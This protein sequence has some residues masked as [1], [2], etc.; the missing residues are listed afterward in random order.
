VFDVSG[1]YRTEYAHYRSPGYSGP[2]SANHAEVQ[3]ALRSRTAP[4]SVPVVSADGRFEGFSAGDGQNHARRPEGSF[5]HR[6]IEDVL[7]G[8]GFRDNEVAL[9]Y[10]G[11]WLRDY[12][13]LL[14]PKVV[15]PAGAAKDLGRFLSRPALTAIVDILATAEFAEQRS[16][17]PADYRVTPERLGVYRPSEHIDNPRN[18]TPLPPDPRSIDADFEPWVL[19]GDPLLSI[20]PDLSMKRYILRSKDYMIAQIR[21]AQAQGRNVDGFRTFG[22]ALHVLEDYFAHS[23]FCELSLRKLGYTTVLPWTSAAP[24]RHRYPVVTGMFGPTDVIASMAEPIAHALFN[25]ESWSFEARNAGDRSDGEKIMLVLLSEHSDPRYL[26][27]F[28]DFLKARDALLRLPGRPLLS[29][30]GWIAS[31]PMRLVL[32]CYNLVYQNLM[33]LL[34]N[35]VDDVQ[36]LT[37]SDPNTDGSTDP[38]HSQLAKDHDDHPLHTLAA[39]LAMFA[40]RRVGSAMGDH[41]TGIG[42]T[43]PAELASSFIAHPEDCHW[44][45]GVVREWA[46]KN[47]AE[48]QR[49]SSATVLEH[50]HQIHGKSTL[51]ALRK[52]GRHGDEGW[53]YLLRNYQFILGQENKVREQ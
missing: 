40:V 28:E 50:L 37:E 48:V 42:K 23:N 49:A 45:D 39:E 26:K 5:G 43:D 35:S 3:Q 10:F 4:G 30:I 1:N 2:L 27:A 6:S 15:R 38:T 52:M 9:I 21:K 14:D 7:I 47:D 24:C 25:V 31:A 16:R 46:M 41:W 32:N 34:G 44:Q 33:L 11:N 18:I 36:T 51:Q 13:Q 20:H 19:P 22:G 17:S 12:S 29:R 8:S 53:S